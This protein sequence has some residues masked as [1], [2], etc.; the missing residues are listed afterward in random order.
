MKSSKK[1][2][3]QTVRSFE[4]ER[5]SLETELKNLHE[6][7]KVKDAEQKQMKKAEKK[8]RQK[9]KKAAKENTDTVHSKDQ[10][11]QNL[12]DDDKNSEENTKPKLANTD[13][14]AKPENSANAKSKESYTFKSD[15]PRFLEF[16]ERFG[17]WSE[18]QK[19]DAYDNYFKLYL[20]KSLK[21]YY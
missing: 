13:A 8:T 18:D 9:A 19:K 10:N 2:L 20:Q 16:P 14:C 4:K 1:D 12:Q 15:D 3:E 17:E 21:I 11:L 7:K 5:K 6:F